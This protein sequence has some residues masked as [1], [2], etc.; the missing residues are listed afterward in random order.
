[1]QTDLAYREDP[2]EETIGGRVV[3]MAS[4]GLHHIFIAGNLY[5]LF[6]AYLRGK[7]C[8]PLPDGATLFLSDEEEY[9]P[10]MMVV[11][12]SEKLRDRGVYG[13]PDLV[14][15]VLSPSTALYD[16]GH[17]KSTYEAHGVRE[18]W[19]VDPNNKMIEQYLLRDGK[20]FLNDTYSIYP[21][22]MLEGMRP[23]ERAA[24]KTEFQCSLFDDLTIRLE[25][26][27]DRV[28]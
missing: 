17:K 5:A 8:T 10:D 3:M 6:Y 19:L 27:F 23:E 20:F 9:R 7:P 16:K 24:V 18:Y 2:R 25:D 26:V 12:D 28:P 13:A 21:N 15:E 11:C 14:V 22:W 1:M 4:P